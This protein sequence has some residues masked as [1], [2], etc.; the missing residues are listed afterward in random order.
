MGVGLAKDSKKCIVVA[1]YTPAGNVVGHHKENVFPASDSKS[2]SAKVKG[3][4][5]IGG[6]KGDDSSSSS[7]DEENKTGECKVGVEWV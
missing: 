2:K 1:N 3:F 4:L 5:G 6:K 7:S